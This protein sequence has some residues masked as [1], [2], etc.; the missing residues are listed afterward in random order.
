MDVKLG[1]VKYKI[2]VCKVHE[3]S[4]S[5]GEVRKL[6][7]AKLDNFKQL[8]DAAAALGY[9]L[10]QQ[11][12][13]GGLVV[14]TALPQAVQ[15]PDPPVVKTPVRSQQP[16]VDPRTLPTVELAQGQVLAIQKNDRPNMQTQE[17]LET[18][19]H[20]GQG[21]S[22]STILDPADADRIKD[23][24]TIIRPSEGDAPRY[25][26]HSLPT[27]VNVKDQSGKVTSVAIPRETSHELK[28]VAGRAGIPVAIPSK[29]EGA[30]GK[31]T[32]NVVDTGGDPALQKR[33]KQ[34]IQQNM[35]ARHGGE[36]PRIFTGQYVG[37]CVACR[38]SGIARIGG[39]ACP[40]CTGSGLR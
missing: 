10:T 34:E 24:P 7:Q 15:P 21:T 18:F 30:M 28:V 5:P 19:L 11:P 12:P 27:S 4:A 33:F 35:S 16:S 26:P 25:A 40:K 37:D 2:S 9:T 36:N 31:T 13:V 29:V 3:E 32:I 8:Q 38:G 17:R 1:E 22:T 23:D 20:G 14:P 6:V 39:G